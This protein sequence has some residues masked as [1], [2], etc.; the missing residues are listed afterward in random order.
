VSEGDV[1]EKVDGDQL[2]HEW[3]IDTLSTFLAGVRVVIREAKAT[4]D[5]ERQH[6]FES[7]ENWA[8]ERL[9]WLGRNQQQP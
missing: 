3:S 7:V 6:L 4:G 5:L 1:E 8:E 9:A 2:A